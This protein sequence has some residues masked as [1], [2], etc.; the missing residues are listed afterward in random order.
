MRRNRG[1]RPRRR[2]DD[3]RADARAA[4][5]G[6]V[7]QVAPAHMGWR[8][9]IHCD[10][11]AC[12]KRHAHKRFRRVRRNYFGIRHRYGDIAL[13]Q[14]CKVRQAA[15]ASQVAE[16]LRLLTFRQM[17]ADTRHGRHRSLCCAPYANVWSA[18]RRGKPQR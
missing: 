4:A 8:R 1:G 9:Q 5:L 2:C 3:R 13:P 17:R 16:A 14:V 6:G 7:T 11:G 18:H 12:R 15:K 10:A